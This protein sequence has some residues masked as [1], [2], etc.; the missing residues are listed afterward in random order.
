VSVARRREPDDFDGEWLRFTGGQALHGTYRAPG[1]PA[2]LG[3]AR[4]MRVATDRLVVLLPGGA[5]R[6][7]RRAPAR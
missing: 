2:H 5:S 3:P 4:L 7:L 1:E 6:V